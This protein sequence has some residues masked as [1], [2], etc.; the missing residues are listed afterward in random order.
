MCVGHAFGEQSHG[1]TIAEVLL[2]LQTQFCGCKYVNGSITIVMNPDINTLE[3]TEDDFDFF[4][5][6]EQV[7]ER[8]LFL[9]L[10][11][12]IRLI[13]P[14]LRIIRGE[15]LEQSTHSEPA[16]HLYSSD[17]VELVLPELTEISHGGITVESPVGDVYPCNLA[18]VNWTDIIDNGT[19]DL[20]FSCDTECK[21]ILY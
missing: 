2:D 5:H 14:N 17:I 4:Y 15:S 12:T 11:R 1:S 8:I 21:I 7:S 16:L 6:L 19:I 10:P 13:L 3:L 18:R 9:G 20:Q